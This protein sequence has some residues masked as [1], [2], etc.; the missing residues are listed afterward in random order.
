MI[1][2]TYVLL[3]LIATV[4]FTSCTQQSIPS[5]SF[6]NTNEVQNSN[7]IG[8]ELANADFQKAHGIVLLIMENDKGEQSICTGSLIT[9]D[10]VLTAAHCVDGAGLQFIAALFTTNAHQQV[11]DD[12]IRFAANFVYPEN[13][14]QAEQGVWNDIAV[15]KLHAPA[16][17]DYK[18][19]VL[20]TPET[21]NKLTVGSALTFAGYGITTPVL[22]EFKRDENGQVI[23]GEDG[24][25]EI[26][27]FPTEGSGILRQV[28]NII[29]TDITSD[30]KEITL[31]QTNLK[32]ACHGDSGGPALLQ[33]EDGS[34]VQVGVTSRGTDYL[35]NCNVGVIYTGLFG[36]REWITWA[37][38]LMNQPVPAQPST[39]PPPQVAVGQ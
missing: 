14:N 24:Y 32:G 20:P 36:Q 12:Q 17:E 19:A 31:D 10:I 16:P 11:T 9:R 23:I 13:Y 22:R 5:T 39:E 28:G 33:L 25:P 29:V 35:G 18:L 26:V 30:H 7:I 34:Y 4:L 27:E 15:V 38:N 1:K 6:V 2:K 37:I 3:A 21:I 8:G